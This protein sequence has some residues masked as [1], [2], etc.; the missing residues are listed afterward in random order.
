M[1]VADNEAMA[2][3]ARISDQ[4]AS[5]VARGVGSASETGGINSVRVYISRRRCFAQL[6]RRIGDWIVA[7]TAKVAK[8]TRRS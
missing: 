1:V 8:R 5:D 2:V 3:S 6:R 7:I 4:S